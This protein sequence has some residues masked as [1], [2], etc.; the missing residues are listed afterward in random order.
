MKSVKIQIY[1]QD[2]SVEEREIDLPT[3]LGSVLLVKM[4]RDFTMDGFKAS[5]SSIILADSLENKM[6][7]GS[8]VG[9]VIAIGPCAFKGDRFKYIYGDE[10]DV[11]VGDKVIFKMSS[12]LKVPHSAGKYQLVDDQNLVGVYRDE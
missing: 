7:Q 5:K 9:D 12:G 2:G 3:P 10:W 6:D 4:D 11:K 8:V 1:K